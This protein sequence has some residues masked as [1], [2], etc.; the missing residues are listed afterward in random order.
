MSLPKIGAVLALDGEREYKSAIS[1]V[2]MAQRELRSEMKLATEEFYGQENSIE[3]LT[4]QQE[5]LTRQQEAQAEKVEVCKIAMEQYAQAQ[6]TAGNK[7]EEAVKAYQSAEERLE[8]LKTS[9]GAT[10][11]E[12]ER[13]KK[14]VQ[15][16][17]EQ[18][19]K[20]N[21]EYDTATKKNS[22]WQISLNNSQAELKKTDR[23]L[24]ETN[25][26]LEEAKSAA[27]GT[28]KSI[29]GFG[30]K[31]KEA[32]E[33][34]CKFNDVW[35]E[36][37]KEL[38]SLQ[39]LEMV[40]SALERL[41]SAAINTA[42]EAAAYA[43][44]ILTISTNTG[45]ATETLQELKYAQDLMDVSLETVTKS[46]A[47]NI[48]SMNS[49]RGESEAYVEAYKKLGVTVEDVTT[50]ELRD[51]EEVFWECIDALGKMQ[52]E[53]ERDA[54]SM[55][56]F[57]KSAQDLNSL[58]AQGS[59]GFAELAEEARESGYVLGTEALGQLGKTQ[60]AID[61]FSNKTTQ[62]K[63][64]IG[65]ELA[66]VVINTLDRIGKKGDELA[67]IAINFG[68]KV[69]PVVS[70]GIEI[71]IEN[72]EVLIPVVAG[73][74]AGMKSFEMATAAAT[75]IEE[76][77]T[78]TEGASLAQAAFNVVANANPYVLLATAIVG[79]TT[80][81]G[82]YCLMT[83]DAA[84]STGNLEKDTQELIESAKELHKA[85]EES[86][87]DRSISRQNMETEAAACKSLAKELI[88]LQGKTSLTASEQSRMQMI[89]A[90][91]NQAMPDL[92]LAIDEQ[93]GKLNMSTEALLDN[94]EAMNQ[95]AIAAAAQEDLEEIAGQQYEQY[96]KLLELNEQL[97]EQ[98]NAVT[99]AEKAYNEALERTKETGESGWIE[100][101]DLAYQ[102]AVETQKELESQI[103]ETQAAYDALGEEWISTNEF[104]S[105]TEAQYSAIAATK[106]LGDT[107]SETGE[108]V[109]GTSEAIQQAYADMGASI[110]E[111]VEEQMDIFSEFEQKNTISGEKI[112]SNM[113]S[114]VEG[115]KNWGDNLS[116]LAG[117]ADENGTL[118][119]EGLLSHLVDLGPEGAAYVQAFVNM[120]DEELQK[121]NELWAESITLPDT[122]AEQF[123]ETGAQMAAG[124]QTG[125]E[126]N[127]PIVEEAMSGMVDGVIDAGNTT[128]QVNSP[129]KVTMKTGA[130]LDEGLATGIKNGKNTVVAAMKETTTGVLITART[131]LRPA[132]GQTIGQQFSDGLASGIRAGKSSVINAA[133]EVAR[134]AVSAA[135][136]ELGIHSPSKVTQEMGGYY[137]D[138]WVLGIQ[139]KT[140]NLKDAVRGALSE[141]LIQEVE[142]VGI[143]NSSAYASETDVYGERP[144]LQ[145][146]IQPQQLT[147]EDM[148]MLF[149]Y[150]NE[151]FGY[152]L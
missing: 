103:K 89:V 104:I 131:E 50:G 148:D 105:D 87:A 69:I 57:G 47:K 36:Y 14:V 33:E 112:L 77:K 37:G 133:I 115:V 147:R 27:D 129:S 96:K 3:A 123:Q 150:V 62:I 73:V 18:L 1:S 48:K 116:E 61:R 76:F 108:K 30:K 16:A 84:D 132:V 99:E 43:D 136:G 59:E 52:N 143:G 118:I 91:L 93:T 111:S 13:Q 17:K 114:Q 39:K 94:V 42:K 102:S 10:A 64:K 45:I 44:D 92:N 79:V 130:A 15:E 53:T 40:T 141:S 138:G 144:N 25:K 109:S 83:D 8:G 107:A 38:V 34:S 81:V 80:A 31:V 106:E 119:S 32:Q 135:K 35:N 117:R 5:I 12:I 56:I 74:A 128:A 78:A 6:E 7:V 145:F 120:T 58:I 4:K 23:A 113:E 137:M 98:T 24:E 126:E 152:A 22:E 125:I 75:A 67:D 121:A 41:G 140:E 11:E 142:S 139:A 127:A 100:D 55:Q 134:A 124:L 60:D 149:D 122:I 49:A 86:A 97:E 29:D 101:A 28:A 26:Y 71:L 54:V 9:S 20:A 21:K 72:G 146:M 70:D 19:E 63:N 151:R 110:R 51:S 95:L 66:P 90:E 2:N 85:Y 65:T 88:T 68:E 46:M 82:A